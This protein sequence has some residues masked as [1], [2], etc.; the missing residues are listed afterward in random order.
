MV[1]RTKCNGQT[2]E[3]ATKARSGDN[4]TRGVAGLHQCEVAAGQNVRAFSAKKG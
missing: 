1:R 3:T 4:K 2:P